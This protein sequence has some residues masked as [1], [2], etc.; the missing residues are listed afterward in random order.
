MPHFEFELASTIFKYAFTIG[1]KYNRNIMHSIILFGNIVSAKMKSD[2]VI[3]LLH[4][5]VP[6]CHPKG[7]LAYLVFQ[8]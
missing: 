8:F 3:G 7:I 4:I 5:P 2:V 1:V 6:L